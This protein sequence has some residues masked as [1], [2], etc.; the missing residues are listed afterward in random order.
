MAKQ[1]QPKRQPEFMAQLLIQRITLH[2]PAHTTQNTYHVQTAILHVSTLYTALGPESNTTLLPDKTTVAL[3]RHHCCSI[4]CASKLT[5]CNPM[6]SPA[7]LPSHT[8]I[9]TYKPATIARNQGHPADT[10]SSSR[11]QQHKAEAS[12]QQV[13]NLLLV[14]GHNLAEHDCGVTVEERDTGQTLA[15]L[16]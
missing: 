11:Y 1:I 2:L 5:D 9:R 10:R 12:C 14:D 6:S 3:S 4:K 15:A 13:G 7:Q 16:E 8:C